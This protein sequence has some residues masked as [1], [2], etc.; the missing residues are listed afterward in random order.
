[1]CRK[2]IRKL[3][4]TNNTINYRGI[5]GMVRYPEILFK[6][7]TLNEM[8]VAKQKYEKTKISILK[9]RGWGLLLNDW[10]EKRGD[11]ADL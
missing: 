5:K 6:D 7:A 9:K 11:N 8:S 4:K 1:M 2:H 10:F 3:E